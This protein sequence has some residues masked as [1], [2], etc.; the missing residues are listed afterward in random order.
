MKKVNKIMVAIDFSDYS[1]PAAQYAADL[2]KDLSAS[3]L[4]VNVLNQRDVD[5]MNKVEFLSSDFNVKK[6]L[7]ENL[8]DREDRLQIIAKKLDFDITNIETCVRVGVPYKTLLEE[9]E[10]S[11]SDLLVM[12][13]KGRSNIVDMVI[14]SCAQKMFRRSPIPLLSLR[15]TM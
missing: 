14:G 5:M 13:A 6:H 9:I 11:K 7:D 12:G 8:K 15:E 4:L 2:A 10:K 1:Y 3:I